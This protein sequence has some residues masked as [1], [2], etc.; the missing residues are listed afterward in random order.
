MRI[1]K[2]SA[3]LVVL[4]AWICSCQ[5]GT[6]QQTIEK[7]KP[8]QLKVTSSAFT[9]GAMIPKKYTCDDRNISPPLTWTEGPAD[10]KS[11]VLI[12]DDPDAPVGTW[13]HW[14]LFNI[15]ANTRELP[16]N[17]APEKTLAYGEKHGKN[18]WG[19]IGYGGPC[20]PSGTHR[21]YFKLYA[22][23][24]SLNLEAGATKADLEK[25]MQGHVL[26][27]GQLMGK[28]KRQ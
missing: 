17:V 21:Y 7:G 28:Y 16:E 18:G 20:P 13:V 11:Y 14:V 6:T 26:A 5:P 15:P 4:G 27:E 9:E 25:A 23:N 10:T 8:M 2:Q 3:S 12:A 22:L 1:L 19:N 24:T